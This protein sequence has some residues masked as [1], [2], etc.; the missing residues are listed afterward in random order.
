MSKDTGLKQRELIITHGKL[1]N[2]FLNLNFK[3]QNHW[4][5]KNKTNYEFESPSKIVLSAYLQRIIEPLF[6]TQYRVH[7]TLLGTWEF[8]RKS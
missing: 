3:T 6:G 2:D 1:K 4:V 7:G 8:F 5:G